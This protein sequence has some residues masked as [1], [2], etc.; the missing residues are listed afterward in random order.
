MVPELF[1][2][3][4]LNALLAPCSFDFVSL[5]EEMSGDKPERFGKGPGFLSQEKGK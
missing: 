1:F 4:S 3:F 2:F 5:G